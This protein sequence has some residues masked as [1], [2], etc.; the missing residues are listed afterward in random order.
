MR[1]NKSA[2]PWSDGA[3]R[4]LRRRLQGPQR[5]SLLWLQA[6]EKGHM[7]I[8][9]FIAHAHRFQNEAILLIHFSARYKRSHIL[10]AL[11]ILPPNLRSRCVPLLNGYAD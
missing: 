11:N 8:A 3:P 5:C 1:E 6:K 2:G 4:E 9:D 10:S 7:H